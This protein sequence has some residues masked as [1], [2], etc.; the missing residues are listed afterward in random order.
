MRKRVLYISS[1]FVFLF[2]VFLSFRVQAKEIS[3]S[4][5]NVNSE[6]LKDGSLCIQENIKFKMDGDFNGV[7]REINTKLSKGVQDI[8]VEEISP[9]GQKELTEVEKAKNGQDGVYQIS[10]SGD[11]YTVK[12]YSPA[13]NENKEFK[14]SY[15][16]NDVAVKYND[17]SELDYRFWGDKS[18]TTIDKF[19]INLSIHNDLGSKGLKVFAR[20]PVDNTQASIMNLNTFN[21][22]GENVKKNTPIEGKFLFPADVIA[23]S[24]NV[25]KQNKLNEILKQEQEYKKSIDD[26]KQ[27]QK[28]MK[29]TGNT[30]GCAA[31]L[32]N[33]ILGAIILKINRRKQHVDFNTFPDE[34]T[35]AIAG[36]LYRR[37]VNARSLIAT[38][39]DLVRR[40]YLYI[41]KLEY[42]NYLIVKNKSMDEELLSHEK[43][44]INWFINDIGDGLKVK[45]NDIKSY[46]E[47]DKKNIFDHFYDWKTLVKKEFRRR[48]YYDKKASKLGKTFIIMTLIELAIMIT[49][50]VYGS[51]V[52]IIGV[53]TGISIIAYSY[54][55]MYKR[56]EYGEG[57]FK[58]WRH[59]KSYLE[60]DIYIKNLSDLN[61]IKYIDRDLVYAIALGVN[62]KVFETLNFDTQINNVDVYYDSCI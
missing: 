44:V 60:N 18:D 34:C 9:S 10:N 11:V 58:K 12:I 22:K 55:L 7:Y 54:S 39:L 33:L 19:N 16:L 23:L 43:F 50:L 28:F 6:L 38:I 47:E 21:I 15:K 8:K 30:V 29:S 61:S 37:H 3:I 42:D 24:D 27:Y 56:S 45:L 57:Q 2:T 14:I 13:K 1:I 17:T 20:G 26:K 52:A 62:N 49:F 36:I 32:L 25:V 53:L 5:L 59:F 51:M 48:G 4:N 46:T 31:V 40:K 35:P 41:K